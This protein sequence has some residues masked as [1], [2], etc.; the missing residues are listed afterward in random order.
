MGGRLFKGRDTGTHSWQA[1]RCDLQRVSPSCRPA[2]GSRS[3]PAAARGPRRAAA[4][5]ARAGGSAVAPLKGL[6]KPSEAGFA[7][8]QTTKEL[9][10]SKILSLLRGDAFCWDT[11]LSM[12]AQKHHCLQHIL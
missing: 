5:P 7:E 3:P 4:R 12:T 2:E 6:W 8:K 9:K 1:E 11:V 10:K